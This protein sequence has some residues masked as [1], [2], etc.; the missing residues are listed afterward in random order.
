MRRRIDGECPAIA[1]RAEAGNARVL[2]GGGTG[3]GNQGRGARGHAPKG[4]TP[5]A[6][7]PARRAGAGMIP[8][9]G[10]RGG[11]R[12]MVCGGGLKADPFPRFP[13]RLIKD[14]KRRVFPIAGN[15]RARR[16]GAVRARPADRA[17][18]I[19]LSRL[20]PRGPGPNPGGYLG[21]TPKARLRNQPPAP[22]HPGLKN[23]IPKA[24]RSARR[25][26]G[27]VRSLFHHPPA[28]HAA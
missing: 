20:P 5:V 22:A 2:R 19:E 18:R 28:V 6:R 7:G 25:S 26:P 12:F 3:A 14:A 9:A 16:A 23:R 21:D 10:N 13:G 4:E 1:R 15:P 24:M 17:G 27:L 11:A 8:A